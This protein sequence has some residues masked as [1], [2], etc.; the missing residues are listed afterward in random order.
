MSS[1]SEGGIGPAL[2]AIGVAI[3]IIYT[4]VKSIVNFIL[5]HLTEI[6]VGCA[7]I[8]YL[9]LT[10]FLIKKV[11]D[12]VRK[13]HEVE[14]IYGSGIEI[15][16]TGFGHLSYKELRYGPGKDADKLNNGES[17]IAANDFKDRHRTEVRTFNEVIKKEWT[18]TRRA[19]DLLKFD[20]QTDGDI[21]QAKS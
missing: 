11:R 18:A 6:A 2:V 4:I 9:M 1:N 13:N 7:A 15:N 19:F 3:F 8:L 10:Y 5:D 16:T 20:A 14:Y 12:W 17:V 21:V